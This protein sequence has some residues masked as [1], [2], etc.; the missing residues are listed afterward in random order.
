MIGLWMWAS[1]ASAACTVIMGAAVHTPQGVQEGRT[2]VVQG[3]Q[4]A[5]VGL[6]LDGLDL[7]VRGGEAPAASWQGED[8]E[9]VQGAG[10]QLTPGLVAVDSRIGITEVGMEDG[11]N[12]GNP[13]TG[14][15]V[16][17]A[18][19]IVDGYD[20]RSTLVPVNRIGGVTHA[21]V[22]PGGGGLVRGQ[23]G[24]VQL[25]GSSQAEA[26]VDPSVAMLGAVPS[27][28]WAEGLRQLKELVGDV[29]AYAADRAGYR[30]GRLRP[31]L[32]GL[33]PLDLEALVPVVRGEQQLAVYADRA[34]EI[35]SLL[36]LADELGLRLVIF[37]A[38]E[39][40]VV[41]D[42]LAEEG[43]AV[44]LDPLV[45]RAQGFDRRFASDANAARLVEAGVD[46][47]YTGPFSTHNAHLVR[48]YAGNAVRSGVPRLEA[49]RSL[50]EVPA[51]VFGLDDVGRIEAG[52]QASLVLWSGDPLEVTTFAEQ[53][54][55]GGRAVPMASR[56]TMLRDRYL[57]RSGE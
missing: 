7:D 26:V 44:V 48:H 10:K 16:R 22:L 43:V 19:R 45:R 41:A 34:S 37:G 25:S 38:A 49:L 23:I 4:V 40:W 14:D 9:V 46:V 47:M 36:R 28:S 42:Q 6:Q 2:V 3:E 57:D 15:P 11:A 56:Q 35:E 24:V 27:N 33:S 32:D 5:A 21:L 20:P 51:E 52:A 12:D 1:A 50:W 29:R 31:L 13:K 18:L 54:W 8:C 55:I 30:A 53:V 39:G 17:A